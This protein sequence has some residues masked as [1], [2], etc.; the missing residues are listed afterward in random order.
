MKTSTKVKIVIYPIITVLCAAIMTYLI[1][2]LS[3]WKSNAVIAIIDNAGKCTYFQKGITTGKYDGVSVDS[4]Y[5]SYCK[6]YWT[7][8]KAAT[9]YKRESFDKE[10]NVE[11]YL[12]D[13]TK[14]YLYGFDN[15]NITKSE[16]L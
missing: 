12:V 7:Y 9:E 4:T 8:K 14:Q 2:P 11:A 1:A 5:L 15:N 3:K 13:Y 16:I 6:A 10:E